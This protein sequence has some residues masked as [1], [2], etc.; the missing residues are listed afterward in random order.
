MAGLTADARLTD[1]PLSMD[2]YGGLMLMGGID[3]NANLYHQTPHPCNDSPDDQRDQI[4]LDLIDQAIAH[5][6]PILAICRGMQ[7]LNVCHGGTLVQHLDSTARHVRRTPD[8]PG[9]SVHDVS[10]EE[11]SLLASVAGTNRWRV[12]SRHH[13]AVDHVG[14]GLFVSARDVEDGTIE[15]LERPDRSFVLAV[16]WHPEDQLREHPDQLRL[17]QAF[18]AAVLEKASAKPVSSPVAVSTLS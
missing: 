17:F 10:I 9:L 16:Q 3:V 18:A 4:E 11:G 1:R 13:Q 7:L 12:N 2:G 6:I 15:G 14:E 8:N 5:D